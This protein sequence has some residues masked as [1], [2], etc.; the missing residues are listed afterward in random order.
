MAACSPAATP[1][2]I[3][4]PASGGAVSISGFYGGNMSD[5]RSTE[6]TRPTGPWPILVGLAG[7][8]LLA[9]GVALALYSQ[10][11]AAPIPV[12]VPERVADDYTE[13]ADFPLHLV[14][15]TLVLA[16]IV[17]LIGALVLIRGRRGDER[18]TSVAAGGVLALAAALI[19]GIAFAVTAH[20]PSTYE[21]LTSVYVVTPRVPSAITALIL[22]L[23]GAA[24]VFVLVATPSVS[25]PR[26]WAL[27]MAVVVG[28]VPV[29][30]AAGFAV[31]LGADTATDHVTAEPGPAPAVPA[32]LGAEKFRLQLP[33]VPGQLD[34]RVVFAG[35][36]SVVS[37]RDG[38]TLYD[39]A[40]GVERWHYRRL[41]VTADNVGNVPKKTVALRGE[42][43]VLTY[44]EKRGWIA[45]DTVTGEILW[46]TADFPLD[47]ETLVRGHLLAS[48]TGRGTVTRYDARTG[49]S[50]WT[51]PRESSECVSEGQR[52]VATM[53]VIYR[54]ATCGAG[55]AATV[56]VT[57]F[58]PQ[59]G[60][61]REQRSFPTPFAKVPGS[62]EVRVLDS[63]FVWMTASHDADRTELL[64]PPNAPLASAIVDTSRDHLSALAADDDV[65]ISS[66]GSGVADRPW[67]I[68]SAADGT[69]SAVLDR[70]SADE[71]A[72]DLY[73]A[74]MLADQVVTINR[75]DGV[76]T[77]YTW[78][79]RT[80]LPGRKQ[81]VAVP[82]ATERVRFTT[83]AGS[84]VLI[85]TD[86]KY[87]DIEVI[88]FG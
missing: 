13:T 55:A 75:E 20:I 49:R 32:A 30:G 72:R 67:E 61:V 76:Y 10:F 80:G 23:L 15:G 4:T 41:G 24:L 86:S 43:A 25:A 26:W 87:R 45:F 51:S 52:V 56:V 85:A 60:E 84:L 50:L 78:D 81:E 18:A 79:R 16:G 40:T 2:L 62:V 3:S 6:R 66:L 22:V 46:T 53:T 35:T 83:I 58:D 17:V 57:A 73:E 65:L 68:L 71:G 74:A 70:A 88:G 31:R 36:G 82:P 37:T 21:R 14:R 29:L 54:A 5:D 69:T 8:V 11:A 59:S 9:G 48:T 39:G 28:I 12:P 77:L 42:D 1:P 47:Q 63:G 34:L 44:W 33:A 38:I 19:G 27:A 64:L 7:A